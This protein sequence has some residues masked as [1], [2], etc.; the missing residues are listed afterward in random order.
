MQLQL[1]RHLWGVSL[2]PSF[3]THAP[4]WRDFGYTAIETPL[5]ILSDRAAF[6]RDLAEYRMDWI[7]QVFTNDFSMTGNAQVHL[8]SL[9][10][11]I[12]ETLPHRPLFI[13]A[14]SGVDSW[15]WAETDR[16]F[17]GALELETELGI[18]ISHE[19]HR[20]RCLATPWRSREVMDAFPSL[21][22]TCDFSHWVCVCE[23]LLQ[24]FDETLALAAEHCHHLHARVGFEEGPQVPDPSAPEYAPQVAAHESW[25]DLI[26]ASQRRRGLA[27]STL[28]PEF[29]PAPYMARLP[30]TQMPV[31]DL[32]TVCD[33]MAAR[34]RTRFNP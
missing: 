15:N 19:T 13:N 18:A 1:V 21:K 25:W 31:A 12:E 20:M 24:E 14:H 10:K 33:W 16:F 34:L 7:P 6:F 23:R 8:D 11:Q 22:L 17:A 30:H 29:G 4:R 9:R 27:T 2:D 3:T 28:T 32:A 5:F 26:W